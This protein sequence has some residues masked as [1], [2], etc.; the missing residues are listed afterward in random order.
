VSKQSVAAG[1]LPSPFAEARPLGSALYF[2]MAPS[3]PVRL[4]RISN[5]QLYQYY[6]GDSFQPCTYQVP[7]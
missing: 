2:M 5:D 3:A 7:F 6:L 4:H 1:V